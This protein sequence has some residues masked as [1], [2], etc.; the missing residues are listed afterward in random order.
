MQ[1][2]LTKKARKLGFI[3]IGSHP[4]LILL[5]LLNLSGSVGFFW[6]L[7]S[8]SSQSSVFEYF[9]SIWVGAIAV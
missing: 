9:C 4:T 3:N 8:M 7:S 5:V 2:F 6:F 1:S